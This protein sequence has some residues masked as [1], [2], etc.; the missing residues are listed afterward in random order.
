MEEAVTITLKGI[1]PGKKLLV[2][3]ACILLSRL[4]GWGQAAGGG[5]VSGAKI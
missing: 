3:P 1:F 5:N 4:L 2:L